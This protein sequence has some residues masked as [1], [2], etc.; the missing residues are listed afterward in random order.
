M[1][2]NHTSHYEPIV[3]TG[4]TTTGKTAVAAHVSRAINGAIINTDDFYFFKSEIFHIGLGLTKDEPPKNIPCFAYGVLGLSASKPWPD[5]LL[6]T[7]LKAKRAAEAKG[8]QPIFEGGSFIL[9]SA[10]ISTLKTRNVFSIRLDEDK[11]ANHADRRVHLLLDQGLIAEAERIIKLGLD[12]SWLAQMGI[13]YSPTIS[14]CK[15]Y[16]SKKLM[17]EQITRG[18]IHCAIQQQEKFRSIQGIHWIPAGLT[19]E[20]TAKKI[21]ASAISSNTSQTA[22]NLLP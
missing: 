18:I 7:V 19:P 16:I 13:I 20:A 21:I 15:G 11:M 9:N 17:I 12:S 1:I 4:P 5:E 14:Y 3:I 6:P 10:L 2:Q 22:R 8:Y